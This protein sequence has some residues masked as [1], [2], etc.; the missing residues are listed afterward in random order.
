MNKEMKSTMKKEGNNMT[1]N[2]METL[3]EIK[4][5]INEAMDLANSGNMDAALIVIEAA[6]KCYIDQI[7]K[8]NANTEPGQDEFSRI[9][10]E[11]FGSTRIV[12]TSRVVI[13]PAKILD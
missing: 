13:D 3:N 5:M 2:D 7:E 4:A 10:Q 8:S 12:F 9:C 6:H 1:N 11:M